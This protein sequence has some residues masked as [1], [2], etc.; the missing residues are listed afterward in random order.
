M[1]YQITL[2]NKAIWEFYDQNKEIDIE[3]INI[4][5]IK[6]LENLMQTV[7]PALNSSLANQLLE[8]I[9]SLQ[10]QITNI[11]DINLRTQQEFS[12][13]FL[14]F[15]KDYIEDL[16]MILSNTTS[17]KIAPIIKEY[18]ENLLDKTRMMMSEIIPKNQDV[19]TKEIDKSFKDLQKNLRTDTDKLLTTTINKESLEG[20]IST[21]DDKF[22]KTLVHSQNIFNSIITSTEHRLDTKLTEIKDISTTNSGSNT[23]LQSNISDLLKK[24]ENS[25]SKGKISENILYNILLGLYPTAQI[26]SVGTT[27]ETGDVIISRKDKPVILFENKNYDKNVT[28]DEVRKFLRDIENKNC[29]GIMMAQHYGI[30][31]KDNFEIEL[32]NGHVLIYMHKVEYDADKIKAAVDIIDHFKY[33]LGDLQK[34]EGEQRTIDKQVLDEINKEYQTFILNKLAHIKTIKDYN[35]KLISQMEDI[36]IPSLEHYLSKLYASSTSKEDICEYC[37]YIAKNSRALAAHYRGCSQKRVFMENI[38][39]K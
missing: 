36:Q 14:E 11:S 8:N 30:T 12:I 5:F 34:S 15:K 1:D 20:F 24:M 9:K 31:N 22:S 6:V 18:N 2:Q 7:N 16:K 37:N 33:K 13:K 32:H 23:N 29:S 25:S 28:Q 17:E 39:D 10:T 38:Q 26:D 19:L 4:I 35:Q 3:E 27:K 21:L